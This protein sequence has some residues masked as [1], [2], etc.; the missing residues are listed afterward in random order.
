MD[1]KKVGVVG[2]GLMGAGIVEICAKSGYDVVV[3]EINDELLQTGLDR[4][5]ASLDKAVKRGKLE[6]E[7]REAAWERIRGTTSLEDLA[8]SDLVIEA[9]T[10]NMSLKKEVF[11]QLD[12]LC[13]DHTIL[14]SNTS[15]LS[16]TEIA[17]ATQRPDKDKVIGLHF[18]NPVPI[19][20]LLEIVRALLT[21]DET[22]EISLAFGSTLKKTT[23]VA[24]DTPGFIV[25][26]LLI[27][28]LLDA[29]R[30]Y[31]SGMATKEDIDTG[32]KLGLNHPMGPL[33][34]LDFVGLDTTLFIADAMYGEFKD[35]R[36]AAPPLLRR[37]VMAGRMGR[38]SGAGIYDYS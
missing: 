30:A 15:S 4:L 24:K 19:M 8:G 35:P 17:S 36:Y 16:I 21:S 20:P 22:L 5:S 33:T 26:L 37:M 23:V 2:S 12:E 6:A 10:E 9:V 38:K 13:P 31:E 11:S 32:I 1:I 18:F 3:R 29:V 7:A 25:N 34:L 27:P 14:T 28:F